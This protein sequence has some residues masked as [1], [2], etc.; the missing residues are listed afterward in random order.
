MRL[1]L[2][3]LAYILSASA[4]HAQLFGAPTRYAAS[5]KPMIFYHAS[6]VNPDC[7]SAGN[8]TIR[9]TQAPQ[10]GRI[11]ITRKRIFPN[12]RENNVRSACNRRGSPGVEVS[13]VS[14]RGYI[15]PDSAAIETIWP[16]GRAAQ[17]SI[18]VMVR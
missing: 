3:V 11:V 6:S 15:G 16:N 17:S 18:S 2:I 13:Y 14:A 9:V 12:F 1:W 5:G 4:A 8:V 10:H 7:T